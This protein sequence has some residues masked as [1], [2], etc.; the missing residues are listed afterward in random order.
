VNKLYNLRK[1]NNWSLQ[2]VADLCDPQTTPKQISRL[3]K[4]ERQ[5]TPKWAEI[6][7]KVYGISP[8]EMLYG[9]SAKNSGDALSNLEALSEEFKND[10]LEY[11]L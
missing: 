2:K 10:D 7:G 3:E 6:L 11:G 5:L 1:K 4:G 8:A 9:K